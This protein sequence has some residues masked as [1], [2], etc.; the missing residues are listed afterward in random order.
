MSPSTATQKP[1]PPPPGEAAH[2]KQRPRDARY[3]IADPVS[4]TI[5][6]PGRPTRLSWNQLLLGQFPFAL[7]LVFIVGIVAFAIVQTLPTGASLPGRRGPA[8]AVATES[9]T[10][11]F[12]AGTA[13]QQIAV[14]ADPSGAP[15]WTKASYE[16]RAGDVTFVVTNDSSV[17]HNF[18]IEG[19]GV[20]AQS[21]NFA[22][23][24][25]NSFTIK[26]LPPGE[27]LIVCTFG[28]HRE[29]GMVARLT[30]K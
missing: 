9:A 17:T 8:Q 13:A 27:Y 22:G 20:Q 24:T 26:G 16:A 18:L 15:K 5:P 12:S 21:K 23:K 3:P 29:S 14:A 4:A 28:G 2:R 1:P 19:P 30:V 25:V 10:L 11:S 7:A 6:L